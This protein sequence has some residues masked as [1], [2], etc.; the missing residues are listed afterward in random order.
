MILAP[1]GSYELILEHC[2]AKSYEIF[3]G[4]Q[5][6]Q[7]RTVTTQADMFQVNKYFAELQAHQVHHLTCDDVGSEEAKKKRWGFRLVLV[8]HLCL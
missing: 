6:R 3:T 2:S 1:L 5:G 8:A 7:Q 4:T